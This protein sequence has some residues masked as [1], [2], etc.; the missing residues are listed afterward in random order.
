[1][2]AV[3]HGGARTIEAQDGLGMLSSRGLVTDD[4]TE[5]ERPPRRNPL[6]GIRHRRNPM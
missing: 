4:V 2:G 1:M 3:V 5:H 6:V